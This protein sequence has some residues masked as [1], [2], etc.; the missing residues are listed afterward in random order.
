MRSHLGSNLPVFLTQSTQGH[1]GP[2]SQNLHP[3]QKLHFSQ[4]QRAYLTVLDKKRV[5]RTKSTE[6]L[7]CSYVYHSTI[8]IRDAP[9]THFN[10]HREKKIQNSCQLQDCSFFL[11]S[12]KI[13]KAQ[14]TGVSISKRVQHQKNISLKLLATVQLKS[15]LN[16]Y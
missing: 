1:E 15:L 11:F 9:Y 6:T 8:F 12:F 13:R 4:V 3:F 16:G 14:V 2:G 5:S 10:S 7:F